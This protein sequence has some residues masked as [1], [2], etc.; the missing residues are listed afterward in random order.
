M[1]MLLFNG[2]VGFWQEYQASNAIMQLRKSLALKARVTR[3]GT[4]Q[5]IAACE[6]V[7]GHIFSAATRRYCACMTP[8]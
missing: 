8:C 5:V 1:V 3:D 4:W 6:L 2:V 7:P